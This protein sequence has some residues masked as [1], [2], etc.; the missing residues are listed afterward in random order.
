MLCEGKGGVATLV[1][2]FGGATLVQGYSDLLALF[3]HNG[4]DSITPPRY[5]G[6]KDA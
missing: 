2:Y 4:T 3:E 6:K 5:V 1:C